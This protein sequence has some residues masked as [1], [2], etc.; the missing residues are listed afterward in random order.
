MK[1]LHVAPIPSS[2]A[3]GFLHSILG[4]AQAQA[5]LGHKVAV[6]C[7]EP[8]SFSKEF[9]PNN[10]IYFK[11]PDIRHLNP[12]KHPR[13]W[14]NNITEEFGS[15]DIVNFHGTYIPLHFGLAKF[16]RKN[17]I[18]YIHTPRGDLKIFAQNSKWYKKRIANLLFV[19]FYLQKTSAIH[20]LTQIEKEELALN[21]P[22]VANKIFVVPNGIHEHFLNIDS[23]I[24][25]INKESTCLK[26]ILVGR[27][28][29]DIKGI[30]LILEA[31]L[32]LEKRLSAPHFTFTLIGPFYTKHDEMKFSSLV[33]KFLNKEKIH[34]LGPLFGEHKIRELLKSDIFVCTSRSE[35]MPM[36]LLEAMALGKPCLVTPGSNSKSYIV[37]S[38]SGWY[39]EADPKSIALKLENIFKVPMSEVK[40]KGENAKQYAK[41]NFEWHHVANKVTQVYKIILDNTKFENANMVS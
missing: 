4:L 6:A 19:N 13:T 33:N 28:D 7:S 40:R 15:P 35:G 3:S 30:D 27:I 38:N 14:F 11:G 32:L 20:A 24:V 31:L 18:P 17:K 2:Q 8:D 41:E 29:F 25:D 1:I 9:C 22:K 36:A 23:S 10:V 5:N 37:D 39:T 12:F 34:Y 26:L 16:C 21:F